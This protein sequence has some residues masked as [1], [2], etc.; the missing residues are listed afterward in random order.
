MRLNGIYHYADGQVISGQIGTVDT[1]TYTV[2]VDRLPMGSNMATLRSGRV[3]TRG[4]GGQGRI[5]HTLR[6]GRTPDGGSSGSV[7]CT[8]VWYENMVVSFLVATQ[9]LLQ[10]GASSNVQ[11]TFYY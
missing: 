3:G 6:S 9:L 10:M 1:S 4:S 7:C 5:V 11:E 8:M 2:D